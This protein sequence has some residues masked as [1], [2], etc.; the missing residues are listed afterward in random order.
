MHKRLI[1]SLKCPSTGKKLY[2]K[3]NTTEEILKRDG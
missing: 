1:E 2:L 3:N